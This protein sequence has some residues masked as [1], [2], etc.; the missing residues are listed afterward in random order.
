MSSQVR[1]QIISFSGKLCCSH[2]N[3]ITPKASA[4]LSM[5]KTNRS[6]SINIVPIGN[7]K[8]IRIPKTLLQKYGFSDSLILEETEQGLLLRKTEDAKLSWEDTYRAMALEAENWTDFD[9]ALL[10]GLE[11]DAFDTETL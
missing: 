4:S 9:V 7:S 3:Y 8:G 5:D 2:S 6:Q 1:L 10:D 11:D